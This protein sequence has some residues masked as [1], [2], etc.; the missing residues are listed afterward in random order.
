[1]PDG[2]PD[3]V[4]KYRAVE[5]EVNKRFTNNW[6]LLANWRIAKLEGN[7]EGHL[8]N[9]NG[10]TDPAAQFILGEVYRRQKKFDAAEKILQEGLKIEARLSQGHLNLGRVYYD[11]GDLAKAGPKVGQ[12]IQIKLDFAEAY[13]LA[14]S[15]F[16]KARK[17][18]SALQMF[19]E[20]LRLEPNGQFAAE[21]RELVARIKRALAEKKQ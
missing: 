11:K 15:L 17:A 10:Q 4:R 18:E 14:G 9:D 5:I 20:Y 13:V 6:Q 19:E 8:R 3:P 1:V 12:A 16:L 2:F 21:T 7:F